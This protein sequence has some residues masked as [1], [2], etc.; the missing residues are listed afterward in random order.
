MSG[1]RD[2]AAVAVLPDGKVAVISGSDSSG[3]LK[4]MDIFDP[5]TNTFSLGAAQLTH[6]RLMPTHA[7]L[8]DGRVLIFGGFDAGYIASAQI[9][10]PTTDSYTAEVSSPTARAGATATL[11]PNGKVLIAGGLTGSGNTTLVE[12]FDPTA[13]SGKGSFTTMTSMLAGRVSH[14]AT[15]LPDGTVLF[16]GGDSG[17][18]ATG[19]L[20]SAEIYD[21]SGVGSTTATSNNMSAKRTQFTAQLLN[22][23][24][25]ALNAG[26]DGASYV[27]TMEFYDYTTK[28]FSGAI[29]STTTYAPHGRTYLKSVKLQSGA[30]FFAGGYYAGAVIP[31][32]NLYY[33]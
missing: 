19:V 11:L 10:D 5:S 23:G 6:G 28:T 22:D 16:A 8:A 12:L 1:A 15:L 27:S 7:T 33:P 9:Y 3:V 29:S 14:T 31:W 26:F 18:G 4:T 20:N 24:R 30:L 2:D 17:D 21:P 13:N 25:V 32:A